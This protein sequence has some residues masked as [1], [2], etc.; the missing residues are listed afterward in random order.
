MNQEQ[1]K[2]IQIQENGFKT[3]FGGLLWWSQLRLTFQ[4]G[5]KGFNS[6]P[7]VKILCASQPEKTKQPNK[8]QNIKQKGI[9]N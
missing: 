9:L 7:G 6:D 8:T 1:G 2:E 3:M 4:Y 5:D